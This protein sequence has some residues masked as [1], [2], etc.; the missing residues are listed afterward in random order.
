MLRE[1]RYPL[2]CGRQG[3]WRMRQNRQSLN[4][5]SL[6]CIQ[7]CREPEPCPERFNVRSIW[8]PR[9]CNGHRCVHDMTELGLSCSNLECSGSCSIAKWFLLTCGHMLR[10]LPEPDSE[11]SVRSLEELEQVLPVPEVHFSGRFVGPA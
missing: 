4:S 9:W 2:C 6:S 10:T 7:R 5:V 11:L 1:K 8:D 3:I